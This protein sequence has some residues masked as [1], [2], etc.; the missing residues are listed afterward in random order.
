MCLHKAVFPPCL[1]P[2]LV[3]SQMPPDVV[4]DYCWSFFSCIY[5]MN[6]KQYYLLTIVTLEGDLLLFEYILGRM[7]LSVLLN[8]YHDNIHRKG[9]NP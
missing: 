4:W 7:A 8:H 5:V 3:F 1:G 2:Y 6:M 9:H